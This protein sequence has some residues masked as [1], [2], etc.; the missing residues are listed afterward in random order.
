MSRSSGPTEPTSPAEAGRYRESTAGRPWRAEVIGGVT[1]FFTMAY[2]V[3][4]NPAI[5]AE[6]GTGM[7]LA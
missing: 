2:I 5:L 7:P 3:I 4:V 1:T 6:S